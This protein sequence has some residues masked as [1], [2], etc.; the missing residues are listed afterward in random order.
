MQSDAAPAVVIQD[1]STF[2]LLV[3]ALISM[4]FKM[5]YKISKYYGN[6]LFIRQTNIYNKIF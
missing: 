1:N 2:V 3:L 5:K 4:S 6:I